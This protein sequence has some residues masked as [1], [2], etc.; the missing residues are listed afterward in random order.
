MKATGSAC[1]SPLSYTWTSQRQGQIRAESTSFSL[2][3]THSTVD[4]KTQHFWQPYGQYCHLNIFAVVF[5]LSM[6]HTRHWHGHPFLLSV[7]VNPALSPF[8]DS[9]K[10]PISTALLKAA[11]NFFWQFPFSIA[12]SLRHTVL[13]SLIN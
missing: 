4:L 6:Y 9:S 5:V 7:T 10:I 13:C 2:P 1:S 8:Q 12:L 3:Y 11:C